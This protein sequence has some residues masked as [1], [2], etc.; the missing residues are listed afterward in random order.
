MGIA[1]TLFGGGI[2]GDFYYL[3][4]LLTDDESP[5][6]SSLFQIRRPILGLQAEVYPD[7]KYTEEVLFLSK[8]VP[9]DSYYGG[10]SEPAYPFICPFNGNSKNIT[11]DL[12]LKSLGVKGL[13]SFFIPS[14]HEE[15]LPYPGYNYGT[16]NDEIHNDPDEQYMFWSSKKQQEA[17]SELWR[18]GD[19]EEYEHSINLLD[20]NGRPKDKD[21]LA[22][23]AAHEGLISYAFDNKV[24]YL[25]LHFWDLTTEPFRKGPRVLLISVGVSPSKEALVG[26]ISSQ[27]CHNLCD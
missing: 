16:E 6:N 21:S 24:W 23:I 2:L 4:A 25:V 10:S 13:R 11:A 3:R 12:I 1:V 19:K 7:E 20:E 8:F 9:F 14:L 18:Y 5:L 26:Y 27:S 15:T 22:N 17:I